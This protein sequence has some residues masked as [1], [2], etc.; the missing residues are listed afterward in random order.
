MNKYML[1]VFIDL[2]KAFDTVDHNILI[3]KLNLYGIKNNSVKWF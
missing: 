3:D 1:R 2:P